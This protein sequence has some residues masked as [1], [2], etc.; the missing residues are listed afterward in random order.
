MF[1]SQAKKK[2][3][4]T[5]DG[6]SVKTLHLPYLP[7]LNLPPESVDSSP[8]GQAHVSSPALLDFP[9]WTPPT[10]SLAELSFSSMSMRLF[11]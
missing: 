10:S 5:P 1:Y 3:N 11:C 8:S 7:G 2:H 4:E 6:P 9:L